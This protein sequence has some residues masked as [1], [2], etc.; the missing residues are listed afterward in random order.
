[1]CSSLKTQ[2][3]QGEKAGSKD[4]SLRSCTS[5]LAAPCPGVLLWSETCPRCLARI[6]YVWGVVSSVLL[7]WKYDRE[8]GRD[9]DSVHGWAKCGTWLPWRV[10]PS[11]GPAGWWGPC[12]ASHLQGHFHPRGG[13]WRIRNWHAF[14]FLIRPFQVHYAGVCNK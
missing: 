8:P 1:M 14:I 10:S 7:L 13:W 11:S 9:W 3:W 5:L 4:L 6:Q 12:V 2:R